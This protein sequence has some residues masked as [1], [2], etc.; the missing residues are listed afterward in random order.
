M[1]IL[2]KA[3]HAQLY[4][5]FTTNDLLSQ[6]QSGF[7]PLH[8]TTTALIDVN[9]YLL[10]NIDNGYITGALFLDFK[11]AFDSV[12]HSILLNKLEKYGICGSE[13]AWFTNYLSDRNQCVFYKVKLSSFRKVKMGIPQGS[14]LGPLLFVVFI[15][16]MCDLL[17]SDQTKLSLYADDAALFCK[18][19][20]YLSVQTKLQTELNR[21]MQW[22][23]KNDLQ[24]NAKKCKVMLFGT[25][26]KVHNKQIVLKREDDIIEQVT[27]FKYL[28]VMLDNTLKFDKHIEFVF[29]K[30]ART[31]GYITQIKKYLPKQVLILLYNALILPHIDYGLIIW[32]TSAKFLILKVQ[33]LQ[34]RYA[35]LI[36]NADFLTPH[37]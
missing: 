4:H 35:R 33:R 15:N 21:V 3:V 9:D 24:L 23:D 13:L 25:H 12:N 37:L 11:R 19:R 7:R 27:Q 26:K 8:S 18:V 1:K 34:N 2:E 6:C 17:Y 29:A 22:V 20:D 32:G 16:D 30:L 31:I 10:S 14:I 5:Y 36:L 28:G